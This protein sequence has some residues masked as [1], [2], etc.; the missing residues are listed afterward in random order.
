MMT[1]YSLYIE[2]LVFAA[3]GPIEIKDIKKVLSS[4]LN[5]NVSDKDIEETLDNIQ[6]K[7][8]A[9]LF[10]FELVQ[11]S[12][13]FLFMT[14]GAYHKV[15]GEY[16]KLD[17]KKKLSKT[18]LETLSIVAYKQP[19]AKSEIEQIRGVNADYTIQKLLDKE[20]VEILGRS[21]GPGRPILYG[22]SKKFMDYFGLK[23]MS[24]LP[25][26][27]D[28]EVESNIIGEPIPIEMHSNKEEE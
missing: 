24:D 4:T 15:I 21:D 18:A 12:D 1:D 13:G 6:K 7:Y 27:K 25:K 14:K 28:I 26:L 20:L 16:L 10:A 22:T 8:S 2:A 23:N 11:I 5:V 19:I 3:N 17:A 9:N